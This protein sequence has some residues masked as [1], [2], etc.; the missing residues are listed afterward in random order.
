MVATVSF[1]VGS[2]TR[3][4]NLTALGTEHRNND[5]DLSS[6]YSIVEEIDQ[7]SSHETRYIRDDS[8]HDVEIKLLSIKNH[9][10]SYI[11]PT[12]K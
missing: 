11:I 4:G 7:T 10:F 5:F 6:Y 9:Y 2:R 3:H 1:G 12:E 8:V